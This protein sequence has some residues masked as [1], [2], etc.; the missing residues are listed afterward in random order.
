[1]LDT[2][3]VELDTPVVTAP[4]PAAELEPRVRWSLLTRVAFRFCALY[5]TM[6][7]LFTQMISSLLALPGNGIGVPPL[8]SFSIVQRVLNF[9]GVHI[10]RISYPISF[11]TSGSGDKTVDWILAFTLLVVAAAGTVAWSI[12]DR[13]RDNYVRLNAWF[14]LF[15]RLALATTMVSYGTA[16]AIPLQMP[17]PNLTR[18]LEPYGNFS[19]MGVLWYSIGASRPYEMF[20]G[21]AELVAAVFLFVPALATLGALVALADCIQIFMLNMAYD[22]PV[23][24]FSFHLILMSVVLLAPEASRLLNVLVF[25][26]RAE[27]STQPP[28][29]RRRRASR[30]ALGLQLAF[31]AYVLGLSFFGA[32]QGWKTFGGGAPRPPLY[33]IW[34]VERMQ[35]DGVTRSPLLTDWGRWRRLVVQNATALSFQRMDDTFTGYPAAFDMNAKTITLSKPA[36]KNWKAT[37]A[38]MQPDPE[39][40]VLDG[41]MDGHRV[42]M[43]TRLFDRNNFLLVKTGFHFVQ[44]A[45]F[46]R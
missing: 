10:L 23:K 25:N 13:R 24:L 41:Q 20:A 29:F 27:P 42:R 44:E 9:V 21:T 11:R 15:L 6:Y 18:L 3:P 26:R 17:Y 33:G 43:E 4:V 31:G 34:N 35:I 45:P 16:K 5:F 1:M 28:L 2:I 12:L 37:F 32:W 39:R 14:R 30:I 8:E 38:F 19:P 7:V 22:V 40:L 46:N 36:D